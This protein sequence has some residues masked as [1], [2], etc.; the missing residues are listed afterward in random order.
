[1]D[2]FCFILLHFASFCS[3]L[4]PIGPFWYHFAIMD[5]FGVMII[6]RI[7]NPMGN[8]GLMLFILFSFATF[9][10]KIQQNTPFC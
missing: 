8:D 2:L 9:V 5:L 6:I 3:I 1:M 10:V 7:W 4:T